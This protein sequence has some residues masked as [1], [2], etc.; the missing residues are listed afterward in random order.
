MRL[1]P[2][3][4]QRPGG[5][6]FIFVNLAKLL[7]VSVELVLNIADQ[8]FGA[9]DEVKGRGPF[10]FRMAFLENHGEVYQNLL[11]SLEL[12]E[13]QLKLIKDAPAEVQPLISRTGSLR[14]ELQFVMEAED[15]NFVFWV[16]R[17]G[18]GFFIQ[19]TPIE[20]ASILSKTLFDEVETAILTSATLAVSGGRRWRGQRARPTSRRGPGAGP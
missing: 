5:G 14:A 3:T 15:E 7:L 6:E 4:A 20:I 16:E 9:F 11:T 12:I 8:F 13:S 17:R 10:N 18:R 2:P 19:A 1:Q